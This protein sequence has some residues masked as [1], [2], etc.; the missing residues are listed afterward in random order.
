MMVKASTLT[1]RSTIRMWVTV[2]VGVL[3]SQMKYEIAEITAR[4]E[5][6]SGMDTVMKAMPM[7]ARGK[8][9]TSTATPIKMMVAIVTNH[10][11]SIS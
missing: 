3:V 5:V 10:H 7:S 1:V 11:E 6:G 9:F 2:V 4:L 8:G